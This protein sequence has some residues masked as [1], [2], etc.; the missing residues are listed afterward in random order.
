VNKDSKGV[1]SKSTDSNKQNDTTSNVFAK[2]EGN[3]NKPA[4][5]SAN[6]FGQ[7]SG[8][9][10]STTT[11]SDKPIIPL[12]EK[13]AKPLSEAEKVLFDSKYMDHLLKEFYEKVTDQTS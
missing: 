11:G 3:E 12:V 6:V 4:P 10:S 2:K 7:K 13:K 9:S 1:F 5:S 8:T